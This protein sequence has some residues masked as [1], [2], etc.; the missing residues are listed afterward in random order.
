MKTVGIACIRSG[1]VCCRKRACFQ[2]GSLCLF[3]SW[4]RIASPLMRNWSMRCKGLAAFYRTPHADQSGQ[5]RVV[6]DPSPL[7]PI[8]LVALCLPA[9]WCAGFTGTKAPKNDFRRQW[10]YHP[11][12]FPAL[13]TTHQWQWPCH[14]AHRFFLQFQK[15]Q[16]AP[17]AFWVLWVGCWL[18]SDLW[19][20]G[21]LLQRNAN[22]RERKIE[23]T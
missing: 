21:R 7:G 4:K 10:C 14:I 5:Q 13:V 11:F 6:A 8:C 12:G 17:R 18:D 1:S 19:G 15:N 16:V 23:V 9:R 3:S 2:R 20:A 22:A